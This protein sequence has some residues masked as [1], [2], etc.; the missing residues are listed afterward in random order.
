MELNRKSYPSYLDFTTFFNLNKTQFDTGAFQALYGYNGAASGDKW[1][2]YNLLNLPPDGK[3][4][5]GQGFFVK[6][7]ASTT[8]TVTFTPA[9]RTIGSS[10]DFIVGRS[11]NNLNIALA[12]L[13]LSNSSDTY[14]TD[15]YFVDNQTRGLDPG[16]DAGAY[17]G[18]SNGIFTNLVENN[19]GID[20]A[21]QALP[22]NDFNDVVVPLGIKGEA[23]IQLTIGLDT[24]TVSLPSNINVYLEDNVTNT[25]TILNTGDYVFTPAST[26]NGTGRFY[27]HFSSSTLSTEDNLLNGLNIYSEQ[28]T[29]TVVVKGQLNSDTTAAIYDVQGRLI[30]QNALNTSNTTNTI[31]VN[32]LKAGI[33]IVE[34]KSNTQNR[35]QKIIIK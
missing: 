9:M 28:A 12:K 22:Y 1:E 10:D 19:T 33:Y 14:S 23:G 16:Y 26:L 17:L 21:I 6:T 27:V 30:V 13:H 4:T 31:N 35:T 20:M 8:G 7:I 24:E 25:W 34:L 3:I 2:A 32:A 18:A 29:K 11:A 5:P 15:I